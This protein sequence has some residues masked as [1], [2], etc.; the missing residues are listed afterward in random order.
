[1]MDASGLFICLGVSSTELGWEM[2][3]VG[4]AQFGWAYEFARKHA[5]NCSY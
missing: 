5:L 3:W 1:M 2:D 4:C